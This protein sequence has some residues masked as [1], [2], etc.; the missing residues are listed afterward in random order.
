MKTQN[1]LLGPIPS[2]ILEEIAEREIFLPKIERAIYLLTATP[3]SYAKA[4]QLQ[5]FE[6]YR[7]AVLTGHYVSDKTQAHISDYIVKRIAFLK[8]SKIAY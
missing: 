3:M 5:Q 1:N 6:G 7:H 2:I 8:E 4:L